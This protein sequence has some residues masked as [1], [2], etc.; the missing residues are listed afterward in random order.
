M[1]VWI[2]VEGV[3]KKGCWMEKRKGK[4]EQDLGIKTRRYEEGDGSRKR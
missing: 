4:V 3:G 2:E 1:E